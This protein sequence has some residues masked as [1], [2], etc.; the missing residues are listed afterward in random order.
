[1][2]QPHVIRL[3]GPWEYSPL[4]RLGSTGPLPPPGKIKMPCDWADTLGRDFRGR[5]CYLRRFGKPGFPEPYEQMWIVFSGVRARAT[6]SLNGQ[7][8]GEV[9]SDDPGNF[10]VTGK[11][12]FRNVLEVIIEQ[13]ADAADPGG[14]IGEVRLEIE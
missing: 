10:E 12:D 4:E 14:I 5:V 6:V 8:L 1:M 3:R 9:E 13:P 11:L 2:R 7:P